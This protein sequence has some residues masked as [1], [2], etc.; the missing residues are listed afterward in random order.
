MGSIL[1][2]KKSPIIYVFAFVFL[3]V[4]ADAKQLMRKRSFAKKIQQNE[5]IMRIPRQ[6][7]L[8]SYRF[9]LLR[10][11][12]SQYVATARR[13]KKMHDNYACAKSNCVKDLQVKKTAVA[14]AFS[15][16]HFLY[17]QFGGISHFQTGFM[18]VL[19]LLGNLEEAARRSSNLYKM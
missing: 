14:L 3:L 18:R 8:K 10:V 17:D 9:N 4:S 13:A 6:L 12:H 15:P 1:C 7:S 5:Y 19:S 11:V 2:K 16:P